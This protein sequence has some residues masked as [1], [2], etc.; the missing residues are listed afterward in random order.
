MGTSQN[1]QE[2]RI[3]VTWNILR[4][5]ATVYEAS[6][7]VQLNEITLM[8]PLIMPSLKMRPWPR[9]AFFKPHFRWVLI[10]T[11]ANM[12]SQKLSSCLKSV[13]KSGWYSHPLYRNSV[14]KKWLIAAGIPNQD[15]QYLR[16]RPDQQQ[17]PGVP[18][19]C[20]R[21]KAASQHSL[22]TWSWKE[23]CESHHELW[24]W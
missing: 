2:N 4:K 9:V 8:W 14:K 1:V 6:H 7:S 13:I 23:N 18:A 11:K 22:Y 16:Q 21:S 24:P 19:E 10:A 12:K 20:V 5:V 17:I 15:N 3:H